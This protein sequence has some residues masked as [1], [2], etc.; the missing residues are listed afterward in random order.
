[1]L[2][3]EKVNILINIAIVFARESIQLKRVKNTKKVLLYSP[4]SYLYLTPQLES[5]EY[6]IINHNKSVNVNP[7]ILDEK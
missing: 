4:I 6:L 2:F 3:P 5:Y 7:N 1:M